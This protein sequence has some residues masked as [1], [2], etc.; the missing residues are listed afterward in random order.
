VAWEAREGRAQ[1]GASRQRVQGLCVVQID[2]GADSNP[3]RCAN[4]MRNFTQGSCFG[5]EL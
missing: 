5:W 4:G 3:S 1:P 2:G